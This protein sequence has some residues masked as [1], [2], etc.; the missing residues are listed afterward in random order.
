VETPRRAHRHHGTDPDERLV[1]A[2]GLLCLGFGLALAL[3]GALLARLGRRE[4]DL[5]G[6]P[7][8]RIVSA[9]TGGWQPCDQPLYS[10]R[11]RLAGKPDYLVKTGPALVPVEVKPGRDAQR[12]Y[13]ADVLQLGAYLLL[14]EEETGRRPPHGLLCYGQRRFEIP[15]TASLRRTVVASL[16]AM[17]HLRGARNVRRG[18]REARRC[19][20]CGLREQ[21]GEHLV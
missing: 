18:H 16:Q 2:V 1:I 6:L 4:R 5:L 8:G 9:D 11:Y 20:R 17:R 15:Y 12:P 3:L 13:A 7:P 21:C 10:P 14:V 19:R